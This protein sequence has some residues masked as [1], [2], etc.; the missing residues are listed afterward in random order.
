MPTLL[1]FLVF[2][3]LLDFLFIFSVHLFFSPSGALSSL[4]L[5]RAACSDEQS[6]LRAERATSTESKSKKSLRCCAQNRRKRAGIRPRYEH[7]HK[8][9]TTSETRGQ[10]TQTHTNTKL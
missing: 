8:S 3:F 6:A 4:A 7:A 5:L 10:N 2:F 9:G 1:I